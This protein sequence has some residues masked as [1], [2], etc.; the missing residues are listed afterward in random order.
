MPLIS[1]RLGRNMRNTFRAL[2]LSFLFFASAARAVSISGSEWNVSNNIFG[3][4]S[5]VQVLWD[6][7]SGNMLPRH[8]HT[9]IWRYKPHQQT[10]YY[11]VMWHAPNNG[12]WDNGVYSYGTHPWPASNCVANGNGS[13]INGNGSGGNAHCWEEAGLATGPEGS[14]PA[15]YVATVGVSPGV[16]VVKDLWYVQIRRVRKMT[17]GPHSGEWEHRFIP[18]YLGNPSFEIIQYVTTIGAPAGGNPANYF[19]VSDWSGSAGSG[20]SEET[21]FGVLRGVQF[22]DAFLSDS[23]AG[24]EAGNQLSNTPITSAGIANVWYMN[25]N[26]IPTDWSDKSGQGHNPTWGNANRPI[27]WDSTITS[28]RWGIFGNN[29]MM[30]NKVGF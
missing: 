27:Q 21:L 22:Y 20:G 26:P 23:D 11:A 12:S 25:Q 15:D 5:F 9:A 19:G 8:E 3:T 16:T 6:S 18:D 13:G 7:A 28:N 2:L 4:N 17:S 10:G 1:C 24:T 14:G 29:D 30:L